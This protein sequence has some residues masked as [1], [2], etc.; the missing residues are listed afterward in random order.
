M[1][2]AN[3]NAYTLGEYCTCRGVQNESPW[4]Y[5]GKTSEFTSRDTMAFVWVR[6]YH[7]ERAYTVR[8]NWFMIK[9]SGSNIT[10][11]VHTWKINLEGYSY[12]DWTTWD[13]IPIGTRDSIGRWGVSAYIDHEHAL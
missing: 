12:T 6:L 2:F 10:R 9:D 3:V 7:V 11:H 5:I 1:T 13:Y 4:G 8:F